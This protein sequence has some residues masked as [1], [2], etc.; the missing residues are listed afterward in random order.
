MPGQFYYSTNY[1]IDIE[2]NII[3]DV[4]PTPAHKS[5]EVTST[6]TM[7][8][9]VEKNLNIKPKRLIADLAYGSA[10]M[11]DWT[12]V[13]KKIELHIPVWDK[14]NNHV[15]RFNRSDFI[16][17]AEADCYWCPAG[18]A[19][20]SRHLIFKKHRSRVTKANTILYKTRKQDCESCQLKSQCCPN[21]EFRKIARSIYEESR[22][23]ARN[24]AK[25]E[26]Y[27]QSRRDRKKV[28]VLFAHLKRNM[29]FER[30]RSR[31][32][33]GAKDEFLL[34]AT[35]QNIK[36]LARKRYR[37]PDIGPST[38]VPS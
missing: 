38:P 16:W 2:N 30:L 1:L 36:S 22:D 20:K 15:D 27:A 7:V 14:L 28:E 17:D 12:V 32:I 8:D 6:Q 13:K 33:R 4:E 35:A 23:V 25:T 11:L 5:S 31:G 10:P 19:L 3:V 24:I 21:T 18:K 29:N 34:A 26:A 9:R 37:P